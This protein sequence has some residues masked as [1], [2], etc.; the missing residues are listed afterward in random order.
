VTGFG[1]WGVVIAMEHMDGTGLELQDFAGLGRKA[2]LLAIAM[3]VFMLSLTG[4]PPT[5]GFLGKFALFRAAL[6][7]GFTGLALIGVV[8]SLVSAFYYLRVVVI[9]TMQEGEPLVTRDR[10]VW[11]TVMFAGVCVV[12]LS[13]AASPLMSWAAQAGMR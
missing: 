2:P 9:M 6:E 3:T 1:A 8:T 11:G 7:G 13:L 12:V 4:I 10:W 5:L